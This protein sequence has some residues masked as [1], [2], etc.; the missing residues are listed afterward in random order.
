MEN[1]KL[2]LFINL[3]LKKIKSNPQP[4]QPSNNNEPS[5]LTSS[6][7]LTPDSEV[8]TI[9]ARNDPNFSEEEEN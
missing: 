9:D 4:Q 7:A 2:G 5:Q 6:A 3:K 1:L 8:T